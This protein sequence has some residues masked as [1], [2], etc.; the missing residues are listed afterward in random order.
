MGCPKTTRPPLCLPSPS[1]PNPDSQ[2][3]WEEEVPV[4]QLARERGSPGAPA[5]RWTWAR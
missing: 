5:W 1:S 4:S 2:E 3:P